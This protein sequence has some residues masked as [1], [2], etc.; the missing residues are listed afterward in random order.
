MTTEYV[1]AAGAI[2]LIDRLLRAHA[3]FAVKFDHKAL[4]WVVSY[5]AEALPNVEVA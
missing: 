1:D 4:Q 3:Q 2:Q 5:R